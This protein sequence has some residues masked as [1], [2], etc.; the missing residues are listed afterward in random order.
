MEKKTSPVKA[1]ILFIAC[2]L[3]GI[4]LFLV[5][6]PTG[7]GGSSL[8]IAMMADAITAVV[9]PILPHVLAALF[10]GGTILAIIHRI[11][12]VHILNDS[13]MLKESF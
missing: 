3:L 8:I 11:K 7:N 9:E 10:L 6:I 4:L 2:S 13:Y 5:P 12:P 1:R